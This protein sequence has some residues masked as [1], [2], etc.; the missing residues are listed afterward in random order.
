VQALSLENAF[1]AVFAE[2][3]QRSLNDV[4]E[5]KRLAAHLERTVDV[6]IA[7]GTALVL[8]FALGW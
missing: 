3:N 1:A 4:V 5:T 8:W 7:L 2:Q 6:V